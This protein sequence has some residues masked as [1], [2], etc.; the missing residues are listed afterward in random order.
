MK[1]ILSLILL[2]PCFLTAQIQ[3]LN[4]SQTHDVEYVRN[5]KNNTTV[6]T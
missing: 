5:I 3:E 4:Y 2:F 6:N 1:K